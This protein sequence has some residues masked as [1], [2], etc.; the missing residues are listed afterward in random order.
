V[1]V[2]WVSREWRSLVVWVEL[3]APE[4]ALI[5][6]VSAAGMR[7]A[8]RIREAIWAHGGRHDQVTYELLHPSW[9]ARLG[10]PGPATEGEPPG[11][12]EHISRRISLL[13]PSGAV[14]LNA[15]LVSERLAIR[16]TETEDGK[17]R[18]RLRRQETER[19]TSVSPSRIHSSHLYDLHWITESNKRNPPPEMLLSVVLRQTNELIGEVQLV[20]IDSFHHTAETASMIYRPKHRNQGYGSE[21]KL[22]LIELAFDQLGFHTLKSRVWAPN[23][24]SQS[25]L[26]KQGFRDAG[27]Y[28]WSTHHDTGFAD[29]AAF[30]LL[31][32]EWRERVSSSS[33]SLD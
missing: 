2:P 3:D 17:E 21:A 18:A 28:H 30:D 27:R 20:N 31:A 26:R 15:L 4:A 19:H 10:D 24:R 9:V 14:P 16:M 8:V 33:Q 5:A 6:A 13:N 11:P 23:T 7:P 29:F 22:L 32:S 25:A 1:V 12:G